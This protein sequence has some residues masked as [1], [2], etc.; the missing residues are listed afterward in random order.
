VQKKNE[1]EQKRKDWRSKLEEADESSEDPLDLWLQCLHW[2][3]VSYPSNPEAK[4]SLLREITDKFKQDERYVNFPKYI[5]AWIKYA[6][7]QDDPSDIYNF[8]KSMGIGKVS[9]TYYKSF[10]G[11]LESRSRW[12]EA[13]KVAT[14]GKK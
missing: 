11:F 13:E 5:D 8:M 6:D 7:M 10:A 12:A 3:E 9:A 1:L 14:E 2:T 4:C